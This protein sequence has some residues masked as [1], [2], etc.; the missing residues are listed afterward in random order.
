MTEKLEN[1]SISDE[2]RALTVNI[3]VFRVPICGTINLR[4]TQVTNLELC[5]Q[6]FVVLK[7]HSGILESKHSDQS[8]FVLIYEGINLSFSATKQTLH[9][10]TV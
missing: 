3:S 8:I 9:K 5:F 4:L 7:Y 10:V 2:I 1:E 6:I